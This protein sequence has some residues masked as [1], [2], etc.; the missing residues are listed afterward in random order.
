MSEEDVKIV[1]GGYMSKEDMTKFLSF[2]DDGCWVYVPKEF[3]AKTDLV[4][5]NNTQPFDKE[6][7]EKM[8]EIVLKKLAERLS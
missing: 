1:M 8:A 4:V 5:V 6:T 3:V 2:H 7:I